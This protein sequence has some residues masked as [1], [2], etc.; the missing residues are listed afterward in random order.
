ML[1]RLTILALLAATVAAAPPA[2]AETLVTVNGEEVTDE[3]FGQALVQTYGHYIIDQLVDQVLI[4]QEAERLGIVVTAEE[5][6]AYRALL[7]DLS[8][9]RNV[10]HMRVGMDEYREIVRERNTSVEAL[11]AALDENLSPVELHTRLLAQKI[12]TDELDLSEEALRAYF[13]KTRGV[14]FS[15]A[16]VLMPTRE[17]AEKVL[18][19]LRNNPG[20]WKQAVFNLSLDRESLPFNGRLPLV[21]ANSE[22]GRAV[23]EL[24]PGQ[25]KL[26]DAGGV[27]QVLRF[28]AT[29]PASGETFEAIRD[30]LRAEL[31]ALETERHLFGLLHRLHLEATV[32]LNLSPDPSERR[33]LGEDV[34]AFVNARP[35]GIDR[36]Q[37]ALLEVYGASLL[38]RYIDRLL[39]FQEA[40]ERGVTVTDAE[41][42]AR[43]DAV[44]EQIMA[45]RAGERGV[46]ET[47]MQEMFSEAPDLAR[48]LK[49]RV[50]LAQVPR[51]DVRATLL[52]EKLVAD[53][54]TVTEQDMDQVRREFAGERI[55]V[56]ELQAPSAPAAQGLYDSVRRGASFDE[57][58]L[59]GEQ[60]G[61]WTQQ[62]LTTAVTSVH[63]YW[64]YV[65]DLQEGQ[66]SRVFEHDG[67]YRIIKV[68]R[69]IPPDEQSPA[70]RREAIE[71][72]AFLRKA[73]RRIQALARVLVGEATIVWPDESASNQ[74]E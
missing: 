18:A 64:N 31:A 45:A 48:E 16:H 49:R 38:P 73:R 6:A 55:L 52:A 66:I 3:D 19:A 41:V 26:R 39:F 70:A 33:I 5:L 61:L 46:D 12:L 54:V 60:P 25:M 11:R 22:L 4:E 9:R 74:Q 2:H 10:A 63:P 67:K 1:K 44:A 20:S 34:A 51:E 15:L 30:Q 24:R 7:V 53:D 8:L 59:T 32:T 35:V 71:R 27:W 42:D 17:D 14:R 37:D 56:R 47:E 21:P 23:A 62:S 50:R 72:E 29:V 68:V 57:L 69:R 58:M 65:R 13:D 40:R 28:V 43:M 36:L